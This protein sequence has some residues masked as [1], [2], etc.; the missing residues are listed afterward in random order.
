MNDSL[1]DRGGLRTVRLFGLDFVADATVREVAEALANSIE[2]RS[3][4]WR[5]VVTP[6]VDHLVRYGRHPDEAATARSSFMILPDGMPIVLASRIV[7]RPLQ[8][9]IPGSDL[10]GEL[11]PLLAAR[12]SPVVVVASSDSVAE[13]LVASHPKASCIVPP[14]LDVDDLAAVDG[15][16]DL[17]DEAVMQIGARGLVL[18]LSMPKHHLIANRLKRRW[19]GR[20]DE[21]PIVMLLGASAELALGVTPRAPRWVQAAGIEWLYRLVLEPRRLAKR[22]LVDDMAFLPMLLR[23]YRTRSVRKRRASIDDT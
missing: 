22:Y 11:W 10:F 3:A 15:L 6:N 20:C 8:R 23:E 17:I 7:R 1:V 14:S 12:A 19:V 9:R 13:R 4:T 5:C 18:G 2:E 16:V 21:V